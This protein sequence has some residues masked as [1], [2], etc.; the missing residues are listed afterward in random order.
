MYFESHIVDDALEF[1]EFYTN[2]RFGKIGFFFAT[3]RWLAIL[4]RP[5]ETLQW[6]CWTVATSSSRLMPFLHIFCKVKVYCLRL[7]LLSTNNEIATI[8]LSA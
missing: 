5:P 7:F 4:S 3:K 8:C 2:M 6:K 1:N